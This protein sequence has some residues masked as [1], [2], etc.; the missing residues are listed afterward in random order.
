[1]IRVPGNVSGGATCRGVWYGRAGTIEL[2]CLGRGTWENMTPSMNT[3]RVLLMLPNG[4][5]APNFQ[6]MFHMFSKKTSKTSQNAPCANCKVARRHRWTRARSMQ[7][8]CSLVISRD[9][10]RDTSDRWVL[11]DDQRS[12]SG[13]HI[14]P[15]IGRHQA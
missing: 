3:V 4:K 9:L 7:I 13:D 6:L 11:G 1:M 8:D 15:S 10:A 12:C 14:S 5:H 2:G